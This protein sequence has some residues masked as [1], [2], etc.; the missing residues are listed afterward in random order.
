MSIRVNILAKQLGLDAGDCKDMLN[1]LGAGVKSHAS[2]VD[3]KFADMLK[4]KL[5]SKT[6]ETQNAK[7][8]EKAEKERKKRLEKAT[9]ERKARLKERVERGSIDDAKLSESAKK[10]I[11]DVADTQSKTKDPDSSKAKASTN[12]D[13]TSKASSFKKESSAKKKDTKDKKQLAG[14]EAQIQEELKRAERE[15]AEKEAQERARLRMEAV[16]KKQ[17][18][19]DKLRKAAGKEQSPK[20]NYKVDVDSLTEEIIQENKAEKKASKSAKVKI[21]QKEIEV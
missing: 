16:A 13:E 7:N 12:N 10:I 15:I 8:A 2:P 3:D 19:E 20:V 9:A 1:E 18:I 4:E 11:K 21:A 14:L 6:D 5:S 17:A